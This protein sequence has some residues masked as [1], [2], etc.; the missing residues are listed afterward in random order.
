MS[1]SLLKDISTHVQ[2]IDLYERHVVRRIFLNFLILYCFCI[3]LKFYI[4]VFCLF[5]RN[6]KSKIEDWK[7]DF[8]EFTEFEPF[9]KLGSEIVEAP[10]T[11]DEE[12][13][14]ITVLEVHESSL[15]GCW[16]SKVVMVSTSLSWRLSL[17]FVLVQLS[18]IFHVGIHLR[19][20][21]GKLE[22]GLN[23]LPL[24]KILFNLNVL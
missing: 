2:N 7:N 6:G 10:A 11:K 16:I 5:K 9:D 22:G 21:C 23:S 12:V 24:S 19:P 1:V 14:Q 18:K 8:I 20:T 17:L 13:S 15:S 4:F 3:F